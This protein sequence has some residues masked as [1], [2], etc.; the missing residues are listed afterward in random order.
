MTWPRNTEP[1][2]WYAIDKP[3]SSREEWTGVLSEHDVTRTRGG[4]DTCLTSIPMSPRSPFCFPTVEKKTGWTCGEAWYTTANSGCTCFPPACWI[5]SNV[6]TCVWLHRCPTQP[7]RQL[8][9]TR[10]SWASTFAVSHPWSSTLYSTCPRRANGGCG[11]WFADPGACLVD[12]PLSLGFLLF[13]GLLVL[14]VA[15]VIRGFASQSQYEGHCG[16]AGL[17]QC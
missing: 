15:E 12:S 11:A 2:K 6:F 14:H 4:K 9:S 17:R 7:S 16:T 13:F 5:S 1:Q 3:N 8:T 10:S